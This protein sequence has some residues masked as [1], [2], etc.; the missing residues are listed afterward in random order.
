LVKDVFNFIK[1]ELPIKN[2]EEIKVFYKKC[3][4]MFFFFLLLFIEI[5]ELL[6]RIQKGPNDRLNK[7]KY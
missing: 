2:I 1:I 7:V 4:I 3:I 5:N 6:E